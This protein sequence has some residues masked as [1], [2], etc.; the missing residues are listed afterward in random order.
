MLADNAA[1]SFLLYALAQEYIKAGEH[2]EALQYFDNLLETNPQY[3]G[4]YYHLGKLYEAIGDPQKAIDTYKQGMVITQQKAAWHDHNE[5]KG[6]LALLSD[7]EDD[8]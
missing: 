6:A 2:Q 3:T 8:F 7:D 5:L 4:A 1:D